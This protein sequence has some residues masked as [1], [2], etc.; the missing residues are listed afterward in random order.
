MRRSG[1]VTKTEKFLLGSTAVF[2]CFLAVL[3]WKDTAAPQQTVSVK[4]QIAVPQEELVPE[5]L[6]VDINT[7]GVEELCRLPGIGEELARR[8]IA[9]RTENGPFA[10]TQAI[11][12][13]SGIGQGK[14]EAMAGMITVTGKETE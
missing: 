9:Y 12:H 5:P 11:M 3:Y 14:W 4:T 2:L 7:A 13:V 1:K 10:D 8:I 6:L